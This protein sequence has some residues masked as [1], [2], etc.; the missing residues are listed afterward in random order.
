MIVCLFICYYSSYYFKQILSKYFDHISIW[1]KNNKQTKILCIFERKFFLKIFLHI[2]LIIKPRTSHVWW[3]IQFDIKWFKILND[4]QQNVDINWTVHRIL[5][6]HF[7]YS[8]P[9]NLL[10]HVIITVNT[11]MYIVMQMETMSNI[12]SYEKQKIKSYT[13]A[14]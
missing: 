9:F 6:T 7:L 11:S 14:Q 13:N 12:I 3:N 4:R 1:M 10:C 5:Q 2:L 8:R